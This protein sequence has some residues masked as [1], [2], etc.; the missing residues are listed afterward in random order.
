MLFAIARTTLRNIFTA[1]RSMMWFLKV[2]KPARRCTEDWTAQMIEQPGLMFFGKGREVHK[3][4]AYGVS[5]TSARM[6]SE[7]LGLLPIAFYVTFDNF[8][9]IGRCRLAWRYRDDL[10]VVF[11]RWSMSGGASDQTD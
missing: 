1:G 11:E 2:P 8:R 4:V 9:T 3:C 5:P 10:G 6:H 7:G